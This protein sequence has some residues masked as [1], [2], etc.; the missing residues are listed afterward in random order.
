MPAVR[1]A[2]FDPIAVDVLVSPRFKNPVHVHPA[3]R[4]EAVRRLALAKFT[5]GQ[6]AHRIG[7]TRRTALRIRTD[8]GIPAVLPARGANQYDRPV[9]APSVGH[10]AA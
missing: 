9:P 10:R 7:C 4:A 3:D 6:I 1:T 8:L 5:D 2:P